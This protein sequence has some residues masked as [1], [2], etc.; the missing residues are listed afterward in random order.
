[1]WFCFVTESSLLTF[2]GAVHTLYCKQRD[3]TVPTYER[4]LFMRGS[5]FRV[6]TGKILAFWI[7][8]H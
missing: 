6:L 2:S 1:M 8:S 5:N 7:G 4:G 3:H